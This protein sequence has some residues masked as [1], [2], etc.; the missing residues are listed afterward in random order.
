MS[1]RCQV[2]VEGGESKLTLY[3]HTDGYPSYMLMLIQQAWD[4]YC[5]GWEGSRVSKAASALCAV[6]PLIFEPLDYHTLHS[7]I[8]WFYT[9]NVRDTKYIGTTPVWKISVYKTSSDFEETKSEEE[10]TT[11][12]DTVRVDA[13]TNTEAKKIEEK[14]Y[15][16]GK[17]PL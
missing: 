11:L 8:E 5:R 17:D 1:T 12:V 4:K 14:V 6:D 9:I 15:H 7:D 13:I 2:R 3:H 16:E 10:R